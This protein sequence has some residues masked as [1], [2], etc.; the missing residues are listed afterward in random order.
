MEAQAAW[1]GAGTLTGVAELALPAAGAEA[2]EGVHLVDARAPIAAGLA[3]AV[4]NVCRSKQGEPGPQASPAPPPA[5]CSRPL[6]LMAVGASK[7]TVTDAGKVAP[8]LADAASM[9]ATHARGCC[10]RRPRPCIR[11]AAVDHYGRQYGQEA[12]PP[13]PTIS[14]TTPRR[15]QHLC[16]PRQGM[17]RGARSSS[18]HQSHQGRRSNS[19]SL[20]YSSERRSGRGSAHKGRHPPAGSGV[21]V[22]AQARPLST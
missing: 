11:P 1:A 20:G 5:R 4:I 12:G 16:R 15:T 21:P 13:L 2:A 17:A 8:W 6:T 7:A 18:C 9:G 19:H 3:Q 14:P 10:A 22:R